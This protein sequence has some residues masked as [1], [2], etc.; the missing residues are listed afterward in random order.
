MF[1]ILQF[2]SFP[3]SVIFIYSFKHLRLINTLTF[4]KKNSA[5]SAAQI[6]NH[7]IAL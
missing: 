5:S 3:Q 7:K 4:N 2:N 6:A 1:L